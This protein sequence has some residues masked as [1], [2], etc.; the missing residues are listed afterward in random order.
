MKSYKTTIIGMIL[1]II[2]AMEPIISGN[3]YK[4]DGPT[5]YKVLFAAS[6]AAMGFY[7][8]DH[9]VTGKQ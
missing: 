1:A 9:D 7:A 4:V 5:F 2:V 6:M 8:K 3:G